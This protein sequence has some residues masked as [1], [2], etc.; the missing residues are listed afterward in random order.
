MGSLKMHAGIEENGHGEPQ[1]IPSSTAFACM[2]NSGNWCTFGCCE[3]KRRWG[4]RYMSEEDQLE[5]SLIQ[6]LKSLRKTLFLES[7]VECTPITGVALSSVYKILSLG[8]L[9]PTT[10]NVKDAMHLVVDAVTS[11]RF[12][13]TDSAS[14][15]VVLM[16]ILQHVC[17]IV[18]TCF[19]IVHQA[20]TKGEL[21]QRIARHTMNEL[22]RCIFLH[23][24]HF[25]HTGKPSTH[26][27]G[28]PGETECASKEYTS[29]DKQLD[30]SNGSSENA[31]VSV[32]SL[33]SLVDDSV[34]GTGHSEVAVDAV[35]NPMN[36]PYGVA[37][38]LEVFQFC[39][40]LYKP[41]SGL[42]ILI[43]E[44]LFPNLMQFGLSMKLK[45]QLEAFLSSV[46]QRLAQSKH[47][48][49]SY[50]QQEVLMEAL[51][52]LCRQ[53]TFMAELYAN[54]DCDISC[55]NLFED[56]SNL[57]SR[58]LFQLTLHCLRCTFA[59]EG[60]NS[61]SFS[62]K[63]LLVLE[64]YTP[65]WNEKCNNYADP[66]SWKTL[67]MG[68]DH[69]NR[70]PKKGLEF[71]QRTHLLPTELDPQNMNLDIAL[72]LFL[73]SFRLPGESQKIQ[74]D[75]AALVLSYS[76]ILL[77]TDQHN[78]Q[79]RRKMTVEDFVRNNRR[80]NGGEDL[81]VSSYWSFTTQSAR[82]R[83]RCLQSRVPRICDAKLRLHL[84][85][86]TPNPFLTGDMF[87]VL[88]GPTLAAICVV[89]DNAE[90]ED[91]YQ[92]CIDGCLAMAQIASLQSF[93]E[94]TDDLVISLCKFT[95]LLDTSQMDDSILA[96]AD[97]TKAMMAT[98]TVF[99]IANKYGDYIRSGWRN[100][101]DC[102]L[103]LHR[104]GLLPSSLLS[105]DTEQ[106]SLEPTEEELEAQRRAHQTIEKCQVS[107]IFT[108]S[109]F[110]QSDSLL[111]LV[112]LDFLPGI[113]YHNQLYNRDRIVLLWPGVYEHIAGI[114]QSAVMPSAFVEKAV[115]GLLHICQRLLPYKENLADELLKSLQV[116]LKLDARVADAYCEQIT[117][118]IADLVKTNAGCIKSQMGWRTIASLLSITARHPEASEVGFETLA[119]IMTDGS[120]L[121]AVNYSLCVDACR[122]FAESRVG[123][124]ERSIHALDLMA[125]SFTYLAR[126]KLSPQEA[127]EVWLALVK[128][129]KKVCLDQREEVRNHAILSLQRCTIMIEGFSLLPELWLNFF[130]LIIFQMLDDF[131]EIVQ[132]KSSRDYRNMEI[133]L[134]HALKL[135]S[136]VF[137]QQIMDL[138]SLSS[139]PKLWVGILGRMEIYATVKI[140]GKKNEK[141]RELVPELLKNSLLVMKTSGILLNPKSN[142]GSDP[143][144]WELTW[145]IVDNLV[146]SLK[147]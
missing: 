82:M 72:R 113:T 55:C 31:S 57:L 3:E 6:S 123:S 15:E 90:N 28:P 21:L 125:G 110:L 102:I 92:T 33:R 42:L 40:I 65:F 80:I 147:I 132:G 69:F 134:L 143:T 142:P 84:L 16:K 1:Y 64:Q 54:F 51:V 137:L 61:P 103:S 141:L 139:F 59:L 32:G 88:S 83:L 67:M 93:S 47:G 114:V 50:Q 81:L 60:C 30:R 131:L 11:C 75:D 41:A 130:D 135:S 39:G 27:N 56:V 24:Q 66:D 144:L 22:V 118:E 52:D 77:N 68:V 100:I 46:I 120:H 119:F 107:T 145:P 23:L 105:L 35:P 25:N 76:I 63:S 17:T 104:I 48:D 129:L 45:L 71:L 14:E 111:Q 19:R 101:L 128:G 87:S 8:I 124:A 2:I 122:Q 34:V 133:T 4:G 112:Y 20:G 127:S 96:F 94:H 146:P 85:L 29:E 98:V 13:V 36:E 10:V 49:S 106:Q 99:T 12:E 74:R 97:D 138:S 26:G 9:D 95:T 91:I 43:K 89:F 109:M 78:V 108:D 115:F 7:T 136:K 38:V 126:W 73:E 53:K 79:L 37:C 117:Q 18:N 5:H 70:D 58:V 116:I 140:R 86:A 121:S 44:E 62:D